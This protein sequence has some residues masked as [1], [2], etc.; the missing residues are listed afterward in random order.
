MRAAFA[1]A[2][3]VGV[4]LLSIR[5]RQACETHTIFIACAVV[6]S[7]VLCFDPLGLAHKMKL[8]GSK[9][10][11]LMAWPFLMNGL[12]FQSLTASSAAWASRGSPLT[13]DV[14][15]TS[16]VSETMALI[17]TRPCRFFSSHSSGYVGLTA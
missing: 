1:I 15:L 10:A 14:P 4:T 2:G 16:P 3:Y 12:N 5:P 13:T 9:A 6:A 8:K 7:A 11:M 17:T